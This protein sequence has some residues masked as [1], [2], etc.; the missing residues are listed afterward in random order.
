MRIFITGAEGFIGSLVARTLETEG[1]H[2]IRHIWSKDGNLDS[3]AITEQSDVIINCAG[4]LGG[5]DS[6]ESEMEEANA[7]L[8]AALGRF[9]IERNSKL[10][11]L[12]TPG[13]VGLHADS[14]EGD[15]YAPWGIYEQTKARGERALLELGMSNGFLT[16][17]RPDFVYGPGDRHKLTLFRQVSKGWFPLIGRGDAKLRPTYVGDVCRAVLAALP[18]G[19]LN[20]GLY[21]IGGPR[22]VTVRKLVEAISSTMRTGVRFIGLPRFLFRFLLLLGPLKPPSL[23]RSRYRLFGVDHFVS[24]SKASDSGFIPATSLEDGLRTTVKWYGESGLL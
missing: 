21:N 11:H 16:I 12:S 5:Q 13:V 1:H 24:I 7:N 22:V 15:A 23:S 19:G 14:A 9:C 4:R 2:V 17:L 6:S 8:P 18:G 3:G 10:I 20:G